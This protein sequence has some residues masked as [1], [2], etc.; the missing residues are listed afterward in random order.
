MSYLSSKKFSHPPDELTLELRKELYIEPYESINFSAHRAHIADEDNYHPKPLLL[1]IAFWL[2]VNIWNYLR[3]PSLVEKAERWCWRLI[4]YEDENTDYACLGPVN[5]PMNTVCCYAHDGPDSYSVQRHIWRLNDYLWMKNEG[6]LANGTNGV[7]VWDTSFIV[8]ALEVGGFAGDERWRP[9]LTKALKF[10][11]EHQLLEEVSD[12]ETCYRHRRKG[13]WP[14]STK[15]QG[16]TVSDCTAEG[17]RAALQ[18]QKVHQ[19]P[20]FISDERLKDAADTLLSMQNQTGGFTEY[21]P[22]R[23]STYLEMLNAAEVFGDI[24]I[25]YDYIE[26][27][28]SCLTA[29]SFFSRFFPGYRTQEIERVKRKAIAYIRRTQ[30]TDGSWY[31][32]WGI[33]FTYAAMFALESLTTV[34]ETYSNSDSARRGCDFLVH[35]QMED[36]GWGESY[37]SSAKRTYIHHEK[38][39]VVQT[40]WAVLALMEAKYPDQTPIRRAIELL[41]RRQRRTGEWLQEAIEGVF[42]QSW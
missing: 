36:G 28:T 3:W 29:L 2:I 39:Q 12:K 11:E 22:T 8:Q 16:Y 4:Q 9:M 32:S 25:G 42:N 13:A 14:F 31:G 21:E 5:A 41:M 19:F 20:E 24:M 1:R 33:C 38:S 37:L 34:G 6:M 18:L 10:L 15:T 23:G 7:Q 27:T 30:R 26:C 17:L 40:A 35:K